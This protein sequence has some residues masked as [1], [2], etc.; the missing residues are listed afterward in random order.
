MIVPAAG[1]DLQAAHV[2]DQQVPVGVV[3]VPEGG[4]QTRDCRLLC[5]GNRLHPGRAGRI[6]RSPWIPRLDQPP[7]IH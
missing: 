1:D 2:V 7:G 4:R 6:R 5:G 3:V